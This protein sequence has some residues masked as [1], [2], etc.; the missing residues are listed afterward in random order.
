MARGDTQGRGVIIAQVTDTHIGYDP[1]AGEAEFNY[2]RCLAVLDAILAL[3]SPPDMLVMSGDLADNGDPDCYARLKAA[4]E[5]CPFPVYPMAG[6]HDDRTELLR[7][8]PD[9]ADDNGFVQ[10]A[11]ECRGLRVVCLDSL[12]AGRHGGAFCDKRAAWM[13]AELEAH[14]DTPTLVFIH[15]PPVVAGIDWMDPRPEEEWFRRFHETLA[16]H[17]QVVGIKCGHLHRPL[18]AMVG[19]VPLSVTPA[20]APAVALDLSPLDFDHADARAIVTA[21]PPFF[22]L[23]RWHEGA[24]VTHFQPVGDWPTLARYE[25]KLVPMMQGLAAERK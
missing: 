18:H 22:S 1:D 21:E 14:P 13:T 17:R 8:F 4:V 5:R 9:Y 20:V 11:A 10:F 25:D 15:H 12:E 7:A 23:H 6:N 2:L 24:L 16:P 3:P 19:D